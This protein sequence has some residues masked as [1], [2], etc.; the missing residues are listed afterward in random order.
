MRQFALAGAKRCLTKMRPAVDRRG[1]WLDRNFERADDDRAPAHA[2]L[3][4]R[5]APVCQAAQRVQSGPSTQT[6]ARQRSAESDSTAR[7]A[8]RDLERVQRPHDLPHALYQP[9]MIQPR[10]TCSWQIFERSPIR[11][12]SSSSRCEWC[13]GIKSTMVTG[14]LIGT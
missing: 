4:L 9:D 14:L 8:L 12:N 11:L 1:F 5:G 7:L 6:Q 10:S 3:D 13:C 2:V